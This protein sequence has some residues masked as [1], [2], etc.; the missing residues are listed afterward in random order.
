MPMDKVL[1]GVFQSL[2]LSVACSAYLL[3][4]DDI[5]VK[6]FDIFSEE[7]VEATGGRG[8]FKILTHEDM[9]L[10]LK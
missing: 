5:C 8:M 6:I 9:V 4:F 2:R 1:W 3:L 7:D 10:I